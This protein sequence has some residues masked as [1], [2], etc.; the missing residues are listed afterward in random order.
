[1]ALGALGI[2]KSKLSELVQL[3]DRSD[4]YV[5]ALARVVEEFSAWGWAPSGIVPTDPYLTALRALDGGAPRTEV[6]QIIV[7]GWQESMLEHLGSRLRSV[8]L[9]DAEYGAFFSARA[10]LVDLAWEDH[11]ARRF[12]ASVPVIAAQV[13]GICFDVAGKA[14]FSKRAGVEPVDDTSLAGVHE[15]LPVAR[16]WFSANVAT[17]VLDP[18][19]SRHGVLHGRS[20]GY[21]TEQIST[22]YFVLLAA[23]LEWATPLAQVEAERRRNERHAALAGSQDVD[24]NGRRLDDREFVETQTALDYVLMGQLSSAP[25]GFHAALERAL[26]LSG[27]RAAVDAAPGIVLDVSDDGTAWH[28]W[29][30][31]IS[32]WVLGIGGTLDQR[33]WYWDAAE[34]PNA[35]PPGPG[36]HHD[37]DELPN[38]S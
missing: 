28:A 34:P 13:E 1:M 23:V 16:E 10:D 36:W 14:F 18:E 30:R 21:Q 12:H 17:T 31:T 32:G 2:D 33:D 24:A 3:A 9:E 38:W 8:G 7:A 20:L 35:P 27:S 6:E 15:G 4:Q 22:K 25:G 5:A 11:S 37:I 29:R 26:T 19:P